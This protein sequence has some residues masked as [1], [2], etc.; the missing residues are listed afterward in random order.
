MPV[1]FTTPLGLTSDLSLVLSLLATL[2]AYRLTTRLAGPLAGIFAAL[3]L[4]TYLA[5][6]CSASRRR[7]PSPCRRPMRLEAHVLP[8]TELWEVTAACR[9]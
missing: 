7:T 8:R 2:G 5:R 3:A 4:E 6:S 1:L 9:R